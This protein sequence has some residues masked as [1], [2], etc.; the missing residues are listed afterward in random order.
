VSRRAK[1]LT[2]ALGAL[3]VLM[4][5][6]VVVPVPLAALSPGPTYDTLGEDHGKPVVTVTGLPVFPTKGHLNMTTVLVDPNVTALKTLGYW[7]SPTTQ[8]VPRAVV[9]PPGQTDAQASQLESL[10]FSASAQYA[11]V[12]A[13]RYLHL[14]T[15]VMVALVAPNAPAGG[16]LK[17]GDSLRTVNG[18]PIV[19][20]LQV[21]QLLK[22]T[23]P[24][25][26]VSVTFQRGT[27]PPGQGVVT[28]GAWPS[29][30]PGGAPDHPQGYLGIS[31]EDLPSIP[32]KIDIALADVGG[33]SAG[34]MFTLA[35]IDKITPDDLTGGRFIAGTGTIDPQGNVGP[36]SGIPLKMI[37]ARDAGATDFLTPA[38]DCQDTKGAVPDGLTLIKVNTLTDAVNALNDLKAGRPVPGC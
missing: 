24:G 5:V 16:L 37:A 10:M 30:Q 29:A 35:V 21:T 1:I 25:D 8:L 34:L 4:I 13:L 2:I 17:P 31:T 6:A 19:S 38:G 32:G 9:Y 33:P 23:K 20:A 22:Q 27:E 7:L 14:P 18:Q 26:K 28:V 11:Q 15:K 12:A 36:I 3:I